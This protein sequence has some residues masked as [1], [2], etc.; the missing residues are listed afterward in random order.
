MLH[1]TRLPLQNQPSH[2]DA[3]GYC[4]RA[5]C[6]PASNRQPLASSPCLASSIHPPRS[7]GWSCPHELPPLLSGAAASLRCSCQP[8][9]SNRC[10]LFLRCPPP[11][12][13]RRRYPSS[14][15][16]SRHQHPS[17]R[18]PPLL[19]CSPS[20]PR[21]LSPPALRHPQIGRASC[22]ER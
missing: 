5:P 1:W 14:N 21:R 20:D 12:P 18:K 15:T 3:T 17:P 7:A 10:C 13:H 4:W 9:C 2:S 19:P 11:T 22:R 16:P 8:A 6:P